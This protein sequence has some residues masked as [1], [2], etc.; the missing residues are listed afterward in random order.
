MGWVKQFFLVNLREALFEND[1]FFW[2]IDLYTC[3]I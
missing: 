1:S 2:G 3:V